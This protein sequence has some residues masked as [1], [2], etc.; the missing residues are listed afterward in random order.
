MKQEDLDALFKPF[1]DVTAKLDDVVFSDV[2]EPVPTL[3]SPKDI[4]EP[5][6]LLE[7]L[8]QKTVTKHQAMTYI[9]RRLTKNPSLEQWYSV[10]KDAEHALVATCHVCGQTFRDGR[11]ELRARPLSTS[12]KKAVH[13]H[14]EEHIQEALAGK[15][16]K[17]TPDDS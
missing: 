17:E 6:A 9:A 12:T 11:R 16:H 1:R 3:G 10:G 14:G 4:T 15:F 5:G 7:R 13:A 2:Q 8:M